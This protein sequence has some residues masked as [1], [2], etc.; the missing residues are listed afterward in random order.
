MCLLR[1]REGT[2]ESLSERAVLTSVVLLGC[3]GCLGVGTLLGYSWR[4]WLTK[5]SQENF[6]I[7]GGGL[8]F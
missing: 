1:S 2:G 8:M 4:L 7:L 3:G 6:S 5:V